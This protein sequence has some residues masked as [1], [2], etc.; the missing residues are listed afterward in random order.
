MKYGPYCGKQ[1]IKYELSAPNFEDACDLLLYWTLV[2]R[3]QEYFSPLRY[4]DGELII[5]LVSRIF[6]ATDNQDFW[7]YG[8]T[9]LDVCLS[10]MPRIDFTEN[11]K[12][13]T[14]YNMYW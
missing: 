11:Y 6:K 8:M 2:I 14:L 13:Y 1:K 7:I 9:L 3:G 4:E 5:K 12:F 10:C